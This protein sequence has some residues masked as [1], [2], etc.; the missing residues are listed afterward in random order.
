MKRTIQCGALLLLCIAQMAVFAGSAFAQ[1]VIASGT[2]A[3]KEGNALAGVKIAVKGT[4]YVENVRAAAVYACV[5]DYRFHDK[6]S[7]RYRND[8]RHEGAV[9][10]ENYSRRGH[11]GFGVAC[12]GTHYAVAGYR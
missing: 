7:S 3:D 11:C 10:R 6:R 5:L 8:G 12:A 1:D 9:G 2:V 4:V